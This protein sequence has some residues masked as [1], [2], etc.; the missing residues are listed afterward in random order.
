[1]LVSLLAIAVDSN[2]T[3]GPF[4]RADDMNPVLKPRA[5]TVF[6]CPMRKRPIHWEEMHV[7]NPA[8]VVRNGKVYVIY[9]AEDTTGEGIG[10]HT[11]RMGLAESKD[12]FHFARLPKP[13]LFPAEDGQKAHEWDGGC[14]DPR[15]VEDDKGNYVMTYSRWNRKD[16]HLGIATSRDLVTWAKHDYAFAKADGGKYD[17]VWCKSGAIV[18]QMKRGRPIAAKINGK[19]WMYWGDKTLRMATS[20]NLLDWTPVLNDKGEIMP[21]LH[22]RPGKFDSNL[23]EPGPPPLLTKNGIVLLYNS[24]NDAKTG[25]PSLKPGTYCTA[26]A[27]FDPKNPTKLIDRTDDYFLKPERAYELTGQYRNGT[28]FIE[29]LVPFKGKWY[30]YYGSSDAWISVATAPIR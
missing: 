1:M 22:P 24:M 26:Q 7:F 19:Y 3:L 21:V 4:A 9:R 6:D 25:D 11:S 2:W 28:V 29:G 5:D 10:G 15:V 12:G 14:E 18:T 13:I 27:L 20:E 16:C 8:A 17:K 30:L 23:V